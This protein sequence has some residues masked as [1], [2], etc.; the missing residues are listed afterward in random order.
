MRHLVRCLILLVLPSAAVAQGAADPGYDS[1]A[2]LL[3][4]PAVATG[5][6]QR[7]NL[8]R[9]DLKVTVRDVA[10]A[11]GLALGAWVGF[12]GPSRDA[13]LMGDL[14]VTADEIMAVERALVVGGIAITAVHNHLVGETPGISYLHVHA[15][16]RATTLARTLDAALRAI[17]LPRPLASAPP[18]PLT[19]DTA[20]L[21]DA[22]GVRG[23]GTGSIASV[24]LEL[25]KGPLTVGGM[26]MRASLGAASPVNM[27]FVS[28]IRAVTTGD[29][30]VTEAQLQP[31]VRALVSGG[32]IVTAVHSHLVGESPRLMYVHF[33]GDGAP[34]ALVVTLRQAA[35]AARSAP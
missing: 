2:T 11:P 18:V 10:I 21:F 5:G 35:D 14:V 31:L 12:D 30:A 25:V 15:H 33:W 29:F 13:M 27:Q 3:G 20:L 26:P 34:A 6:Y 23:R 8:P 7:F 28:A 19:A 32:I 22:M 24:T 17:A 4:T 9:R 16:G 1:V